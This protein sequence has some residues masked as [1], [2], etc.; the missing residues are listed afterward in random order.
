LKKSYNVDEVPDDGNLEIPQQFVDRMNR[1]KGVEAEYIHFASDNRPLYHGWK[2]V[3][4]DYLTDIPDG[5]RYTANHLFEFSQGQLTM[6]PTF[7]DSA[8]YTHSFMNIKDLENIRRCLLD[9]IIGSGLSLQDSTPS[10]LRS[11]KHPEM[12]L[13]MHMYS[14]LIY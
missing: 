1:I 5:M 7:N 4:K 12:A 11:S 14:L 8:T 13:G 6:K 3:M 9:R 2:D 10:I